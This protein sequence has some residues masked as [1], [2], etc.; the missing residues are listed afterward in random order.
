MHFLT[1]GVLRT[2]RLDRLAARL[3]GLG[4]G[5]GLHFSGTESAP[6]ATWVAEVRGRPRTGLEV[7]SVVDR[8]G[9]LLNVSQ[10]QIAIRGDVVP[11]DASLRADYWIAGYRGWLRPPCPGVYRFRFVHDGAAE[12]RLDERWLKKW[13]ASDEPRSED[14]ALELTGRPVAL[15]LDFMRRGSLR[16]TCVL[17]WQRPDRPGVWE[18]VPPEAF[19]PERRHAAPPD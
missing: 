18:T 5:S 19:F 14:F 10:T 11:S 1:H 13:D 3:D 7:N 17:R 12:L 8:D 6:E 2:W 16:G 9:H 15:W 4:L